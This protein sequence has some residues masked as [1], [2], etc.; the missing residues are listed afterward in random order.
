MA[1]L[2]DIR[3]SNKSLSDLPPG[4]V[5]VFAGATSGI[6]LGTLKALAKHANAPRAYIIGRSKEKAPHIIDKL[7]LV[8]PM[9]TFVFIEGQFSLIKDVDKMCEEIK[10]FETHVDIL[11]MSPGYVGLGGRRGKSFPEIIWNFSDET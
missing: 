11:C 6:G 4:I 9:A 8:N 7:K 3:N 10:R 2:S 1:S 5:A